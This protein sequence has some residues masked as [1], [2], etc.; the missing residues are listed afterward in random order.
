MLRQQ[1]LSRLRRFFPR[2]IG[3]YRIRMHLTQERLAEKLCMSARS[4]IQLEHG[5]IGCSCL[6]VVLFLL[7]LTDDEILQLLR[8]IRKEL[9]EAARHD[10]A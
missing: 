8:G 5:E 9:Q 4:Y 10:A 6:T 2:E 1:Y 3:K 7:L